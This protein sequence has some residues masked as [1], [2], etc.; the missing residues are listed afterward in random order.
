[1]N[2]SPGNPGRNRLPALAVAL[3]LG[4]LSPGHLTGRPGAPQQSQTLQYD[5]RVVNIEVPVRVFDGDFFVEN[6]TIDDFEVYENGVPQ[7][8]QAIYLIKKSAVERREEKT[9]FAPKTDRNFFLFFQIYAY[10]PKI[11]DAV[12]YFVGDILKPGD[13]LTVVT[14]IRPYH[15]K[16]EWIEKSSKDEIAR[17]LVG[18][19]KRDTLVG[20]TE[21]RSILDELKRMLT[22]GGVDMTGAAQPDLAAYGEGSWQEFLMNYRDLRERLEKIRSLDGER[23]L[24][25]ADYLKKMDGQKN[26]LLIYQKEYMPMVDRKKYIGRFESG[27]EDMLIEQDFKDLFDLYKRDVKIDADR[28]KKTFSDASIA[29]HFLFLT[30]APGPGPGLGEAVMEEHSEDIYSPFLEMAKATGGVA[31]SSSNPAFMMRKAGEA[32]ENYYLLYYK[33]ENPAADGKFREIK[34][35]VRNKSY[36]ILHRAGYFAR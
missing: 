33:P 3:F 2:E 13:S 6:L 22:G 26:V 28:I 18:L 23:L 7:K 20:N 8:L 24:S 9:P 1:M 36:R 16:K 15:L 5:V 11:E 4:C 34:I 10:H 25:F 19:V 14:S 30:G 31:E 29:I 12:R 27:G 32:S 21:Y 35:R 17:Q